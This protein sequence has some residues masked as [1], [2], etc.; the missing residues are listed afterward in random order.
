MTAPL[1]VPLVESEAGVVGGNSGSGLACNVLTFSRLEVPGVSAVFPGLST[2][3]MVSSSSV[4]VLVLGILTELLEDVRLADAAEAL[5]LLFWWTASLTRSMSVLRSDICKHSTLFRAGVCF[6]YLGSGFLKH[7]QCVA[8]DKSQATYSL[9]A[10]SSDSEC[11]PLPCSET[12]DKPTYETI[13]NLSSIM[14]RPG[15]SHF[16]N[17]DCDVNCVCLRLSA[18]NMSRHML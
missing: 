5:R 4:L 14:T 16:I 7:S 15:Y 10:D 9:T 18:L 1:S 8:S 3:E 6:D 12:R 17:G 2:T 11:S 13:Y